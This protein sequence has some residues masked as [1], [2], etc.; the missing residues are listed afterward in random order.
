MTT[1]DSSECKMGRVTLREL[2]GCSGSFGATISE[3][4]EYILHTNRTGQKPSHGLT[5]CSDSVSL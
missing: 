4:P 3:Y 5:P 1:T 2:R